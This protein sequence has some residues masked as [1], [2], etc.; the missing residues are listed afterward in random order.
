MA[1]IGG[2]CGRFS[3]LSFDFRHKV[4]CVDRGIPVMDADAPAAIRKIES[5][6]PTEPA[7][8]AGHEHGP[9]I[10]VLSHAVLL[11]SFAEPNRKANSW[12]PKATLSAIPSGNK[13][14]PEVLQTR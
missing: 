3:A 4:Q 1:E 12:V 13:H 14:E 8:R 5:N 10:L 6:G 9:G 2:E 7:S 11:G